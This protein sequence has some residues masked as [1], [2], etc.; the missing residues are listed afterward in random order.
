MP[1]VNSSSTSAL[2]SFTRSDSTTDRNRGESWLSRKMAGSI[3]VEGRERERERADSREM[4]EPEG[5][6]ADAMASCTV[7]WN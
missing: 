5:E 4:R 2:R 7:K 3:G 1:R 6:K